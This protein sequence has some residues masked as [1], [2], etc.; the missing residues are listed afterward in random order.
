MFAE[1]VYSQ[2]LHGRHEN[3]VFSLVEIL[4]S[5]V[6]HLSR[7]GRGHEERV[8]NVAWRPSSSRLKMEGKLDR[9]DG[10]AAGPIKLGNVE[11]LFLKGSSTLVFGLEKDW[12]SLLIGCCK[13]GM[14]VYGRAI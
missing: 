11:E 14:V 2:A 9:N 6:P 10:W 3:H 8:W 13:R 1:G 5:H 12:E 7:D 4:V